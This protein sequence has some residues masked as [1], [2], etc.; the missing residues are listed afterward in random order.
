M[1]PREFYELVRMTRYAQK[2]FFSATNSIEKQG[3]LATSKG[4]EKKLDDEIGRVDKII[5]E[6]GL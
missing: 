3:W 1:N 2:Q 5:K 6:K 4:Y